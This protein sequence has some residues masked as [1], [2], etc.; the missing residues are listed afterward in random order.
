M[1]PEIARTIWNQMQEE[2]RQAITD[3]VLE[4][5]KCS[6]DSCPIQPEETPSHLE[7]YWEKLLELIQSQNKYLKK[8]SE[9]LET[10]TKKLEK[11]AGKM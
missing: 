10:V 9:N 4:E 5:L 8:H 7:K 11:I 6:S 3:I 1:A 2:T